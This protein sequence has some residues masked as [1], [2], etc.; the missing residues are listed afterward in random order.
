[1]EECADESLINSFL[2]HDK[3]TNAC[4]LYKNGKVLCSDS[5]MITAL[6]FKCHNFLLLY[7]YSTQY[8]VNLADI[9]MTADIMQLGNHCLERFVL[10]MIY[11]IFH[12]AA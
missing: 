8:E 9:T 1:M 7:M 4:D 11:V 5:I 2:K 3:E 12:I 10:L 6:K